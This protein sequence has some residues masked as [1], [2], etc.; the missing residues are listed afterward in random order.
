MKPGDLVM[1]AWPTEWSKVDD[2]FNWEHA[3]LGLVVEVLSQRPQDSAVEA[4]LLVLHEGERF[5][6]P[7]VWCKLLKEVE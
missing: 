2:P 1:F 3:R 6:V 5:S 4:W 7:A